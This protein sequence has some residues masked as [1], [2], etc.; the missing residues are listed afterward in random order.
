[1]TSPH[2]TP[3]ARLHLLTAFACRASWELCPYREAPAA[4]GAQAQRGHSQPQAP[5]AAR[6]RASGGEIAQTPQLQPFRAA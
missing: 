4:S 6:P 3:A 5:K 2:H 1:M